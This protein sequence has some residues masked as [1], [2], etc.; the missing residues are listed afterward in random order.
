MTL[1][2]V[3]AHHEWAAE[4]CDGE[5]SEEHARLAAWLRELREAKAENVKLRKYAK[6][7]GLAISNDGCGCCPYDLKPDVCD[8]GI[9]PMRNGCMLYEEMCKLGIEA[10]T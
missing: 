7:L 8:T 5:T 1:E 3:I 9:L 4:N 2:E 10:K 6:L